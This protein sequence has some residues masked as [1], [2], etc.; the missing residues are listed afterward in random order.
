MCPPWLTAS[1][2]TLS[3]E[4]APRNINRQGPQTAICGNDSPTSPRL[5][6]ASPSP[7]K[8]RAVPQARR[9]QQKLSAQFGPLIRNPPRT[10]AFA[11]HTKLPD[12]TH[13]IRANFTRSQEHREASM[14]ATHGRASFL[15]TR[16]AHEFGI[17]H[18]TEYG[19]IP[20]HA[21]STSS[22][23]SSGTRSP[24]HPRSRGEHI[25]NDEG[26][27]V[28]EGSSPLTRG[29]PPPANPGPR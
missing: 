8:R 9:H 12:R 25:L 21:G 1:R 29:A 4:S 17:T 10:R 13:P 22:S 23:H 7:R 16:G 15:L 18:S 6:S 24:A 20:A 19:L 5:F 3:S 11:Q 26:E 14:T 28:D 27:W 2:A